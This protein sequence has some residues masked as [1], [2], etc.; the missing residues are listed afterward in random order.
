MPSLASA[1]NGLCGIVVDDLAE[2]LAGVQPFVLGER[3]VAAV[4]EEPVGLGGIGGQDIFL[5]A[6]G[7]GAEQQEQY[8]QATECHGRARKW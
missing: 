6:A 8:R 2:V 3:L 7:G 1:R 5:A 4:D